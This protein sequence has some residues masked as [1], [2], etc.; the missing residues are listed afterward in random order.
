MVALASAGGRFAA[1]LRRNRTELL[2]GTVLALAILAVLTSYGAL[3]LAVAAGEPA[4]ILN[5]D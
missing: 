1:G 5:G 2:S 3:D 4:P